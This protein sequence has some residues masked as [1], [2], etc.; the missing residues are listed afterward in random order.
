MSFVYEEADNN[1]FTCSIIFLGKILRHV[2]S[3]FK[4]LDHYYQVA[5][6]PFIVI[7][8]V[9]LDKFTYL[10]IHFSKLVIILSLSIPG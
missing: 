10:P 8:T 5:L 4:I 9:V 7:Y 6:H 2:I 1:L 3:A